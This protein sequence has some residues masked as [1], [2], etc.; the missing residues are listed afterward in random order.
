MRAALVLQAP[1]TEPH[2]VAAALP[3]VQRESLALPV[4]LGDAQRDDEAEGDPVPHALSP[5]DAVPLPES[6]PVPLRD[7]A[8]EMDSDARGGGEAELRPDTE[9]L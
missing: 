1:L 8:A 7:G 9:L 6:E 3:L 4:E 5:P 2:E